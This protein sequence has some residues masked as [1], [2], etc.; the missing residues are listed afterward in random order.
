MKEIFLELISLKTLRVQNVWSVPDALI[1]E[2]YSPAHKKLYLVNDFSRMTPTMHVQT[3]KPLGAKIASNLS[4]ILRKYILSGLFKFEL[5]HN[6]NILRANF[7]APHADLVLLF[8]FTFRPQ[9]ALFIAHKLIVQAHKET[10]ALLCDNNHIIF[11]PEISLI[12]NIKRAEEYQI[13]KNNFIINEE[14][15][16]RNKELRKLETLKKNLDADLIKFKTMLAQ[17][18]VAELVR[19]NI[20]TIKKNRSKAV[21]TDYFSDPPGEITVSLDPALSP[22][23]MLENMFSKIKKARR[24]VAHI[25]PRLEA[26][27]SRIQKL[28]DQTICD[29]IEPLGARPQ[30]KLPRTKEKNALRVPY[31]VYMSSDNI[32]LW[33]G[34]SARDNDALVLHHARKKEWWFHVRDTTGSHVIVKSIEDAIKPNTMIEAAMLAGYFSAY[35]YENNPEIIYTRVKNLRKPKGL[36][37]GKI[38]VDNEK[39]FFVEIERERLLKLLAQN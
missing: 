9:I 33:V 30:D 6:E 8:D 22:Q 12:N 29:Q 19:V 2:V 11:E 26:L 18:R 32:P 38:L 10:Q 34:K 1:I 36:S 13:Q 24:G 23:K 20:H 25:I 35:K 15:K 39:S 3:H 5:T 27:N 14:K 17:E 21:L 31:R 16:E 7:L 28:K 37:P 4:L